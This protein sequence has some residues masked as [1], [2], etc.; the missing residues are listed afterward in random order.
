MW[1][2]FDKYICQ[3]WLN[4]VF[5]DVLN[6]E[7]ESRPS[8]EWFQG[9]DFFL[10][11]R[12]GLYARKDSTGA[13]V[14]DLTWNI[15]WSIYSDQKI[16]T[17][18]DSWY[19]Y[20]FDWTDVTAI[21]AS[22]NTIQAVVGW[23]DVKLDV[24]SSLN[25]RWQ[26]F[27]ITGWNCILKTI[28][29]KIKKT[30]TPWASATIRMHLTT[31]AAKWTIVKTS[32]TVLTPDLIAGTYW[33]FTFSFPNYSLTNAAK[34][35]F[36]VEADNTDWSNYYSIDTDGAAWYASNDAYS[37]NW[38]TWS[39]VT[40]KDLY[41]IV[42][43][44]LPLAYD[45]VTYDQDVLR[46]SYLGWGRY[47]DATTEFT[48]ASYAPLTATITI[49]ETLTPTQ[50]T[51]MIWK[52]LY[53]SPSWWASVAYRQQQAIIDIPTNQTIKVRADY[54]VWNYPIA[55]NKIQIFNRMESQLRY[56]Q[57]RKGTSTADSSYLYARDN[58]WNNLYWYFPNYAK[59][60][61][62]DSRLI[63][64][65]KDRQGIIA[66]NNEN[67]EVLTSITVNFW[68]ARALNMITYGWYL[69]IFFAD[70]VGIVRKD[71]INPA[72]GTFAYYYQDLLNVWL[73]SAK[74][75]LT[76]WGNLYI[77]WSDKKFY[78]VDLGTV[79]LWEVVAKTTDQGWLLVNYFSAFNGWDVTMHY[80]GWVLYIVYR[81]L[82]ETQV[83][84]YNSTYK[85]WLR[86]EYAI[87]ANLMNFIYMIWVTKYTCSGNT[88][89]AM[90]WIKD[91]SANI[92][93]YL[94]AYG[95]VEW[96]FDLFTRLALKLRF[97]F[98]IYWI[99]G[100]VKITVGGT[101]IY[102]KT[103]D[104]ANLD[105]VQEINALIDTDGTFWSDITGDMLLWWDATV[106]IATLRSLYAEILD[107]YLK[108]GRKWTYLTFEIE[109][110][111]ARQLYVWAVVT[112]YNTHNP[113]FLANK[114]I[115]K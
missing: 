82:S 79:T 100:V 4:T 99:W 31:A 102:K 30:W 48:V 77:F 42:A 112:Y 27:T 93:Q 73:Y 89:Y 70:K 12:D 9:T 39:V 20:N 105:I 108:V 110:S 90:T 85:V 33:T 2:M 36:Y 88:L 21:Q 83:F 50:M 114:L 37:N 52:Y 46:M 80:V 92:V 23:T 24:A 64:L 6:C 44:S 47:P 11:K 22:I 81:L 113:L 62:W 17:Y 68:N 32:S 101:H 75:F 10:R 35:F 34:Y 3:E 29:V 7:I 66:T 60:I 13:S 97:W 86:D 61:A 95:V 43:T 45:W 18:T 74:S 14:R 104:L 87:A 78:A 72:T 94:K 8:K 109:N 53:L 91:I 49:S 16:R 67:F 115:M 111:T 84:K 58:S 56:P 54:D 1:L 41:F 98:D 106:T 25:K 96:T 15:C 26:E 69:I 55:W 63:L 76:E 51:D 103:Y 19:L 71:I 38:I 57:L 40:T 28:S 5:T 59:I 65:K 107:A